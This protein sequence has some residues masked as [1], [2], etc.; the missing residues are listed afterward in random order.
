MEDSEG[1][2]GLKVNIG[3]QGSLL[4][5]GQKQR[6]GIARALIRNPRALLLDEPTSA[7][8]N[9]SEKQVLEALER[10]KSG[11]SMLVI[12]HSKETVAKAD[13]VYVLK[14]G[15]VV[16]R[17]T[18]SELKEVDGEFTRIMAI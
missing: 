12:S 2:Q 3:P 9:E 11:R 8:D 5:G 13:K 15:K 17:G 4:S 7:L 14:H 16:Q 10:G 18:Y 6:V 1:R